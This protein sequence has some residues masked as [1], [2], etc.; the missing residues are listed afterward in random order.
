M[1]IDRFLPEDLARA[2]KAENL[3]LY[4]SSEMQEGATT[5]GSERV[6]ISHRPSVESF[7]CRFRGGDV[8]KWVGYDG[9]NE[10]SSC[11]RRFTALRHLQ[12]KF[13]CVEE[14]IEE[15]MNLIGAAAADVAPAV[16]SAVSSESLRPT[17]SY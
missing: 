5:G 10:A 11:V 16:Q 12:R 13:K 15:A 1:V 7:E 2:V 8:L 6:G 4:Q 3:K 14:Q 9:Q 17:S